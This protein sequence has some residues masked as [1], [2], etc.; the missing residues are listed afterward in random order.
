MTLVGA[1]G[2]GIGEIEDVLMDEAG[3]PVA[4]AAEVGDFLDVDDRDVVIPL[5]QLTLSGDR[6]ATTLTREAI[7]ALPDWD[8][9]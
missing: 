1:D 3:Q 4:V 5:D 9:D 7:E 6:L 2:A 8:D